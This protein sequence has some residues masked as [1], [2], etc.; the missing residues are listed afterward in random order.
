[1]E[2]KFEVE[3][4]AKKKLFEINIKELW[5][6]RDLILLFVK[7]NFI[8]QYKQTVLGPA[9]A[10]IQPLFTTII[11]TVVFG[12]VAGLAPSGVPS[13]AFYLC[14]SIAWTY[15]S[16]CLTATA[17]TFTA[18]SA[19]MGKV[20]FPRLVMPVS[21]VMSQ[22]ISFGI[23]FAMFLVVWIIYMVTGSSI[24]PNLYALMLPIAVIQLAC[25]SLGFGII[26][27]ALTT[28]YRDLVMLISFGVQLWMYA[29]PVAYDIS[30]IPEAYRS[31]YML[32]PVTPI[33]NML[34]YGFLGVG[35]P[36]LAEYAVSWVTTLVVL[37]LGV[38]LFN[39][40]EKTFMDTV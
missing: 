21:T 22:L 4:T 34:R 3:I 40:V 28:K 9:W 38:V 2:Q 35:I 33:I 1:M 36:C 13:F 32:N 24:H 25:L 31:L 26:I 39:R 11:F 20:Y 8:A 17:T 6:Y 5:R 10:I 19:I 18:N 23:Q 16:G 12:N 14:G 37:L 27:S 7:R 29:S 30:I 15:F